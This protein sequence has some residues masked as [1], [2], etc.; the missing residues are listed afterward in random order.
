MENLLISA[1]LMGAA[2]KYSGGNNALD[3]EKLAKL[4]EEYIFIPVCP[5][6]AGGLP[7]PR[8]PGERQ[9]SLVVSNKGR[10]VTAEYEKGANTALALCRRFDC[11]KALLKEK[12]PS[13]GSGEI[14]DGSFTGTVVPGY[15]VAAEKLRDAGIEIFG[16]TEMEKLI[17]T[18][19]HLFP[20]G[21]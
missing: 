7:V 19:G 15:G 8:D 5:E 10:E 4:R 14:Y 21:G 3:G 2:C 9:G 11:R 6:F 17:K 18:P 1:C 16:E 13:C 20:T 12:S